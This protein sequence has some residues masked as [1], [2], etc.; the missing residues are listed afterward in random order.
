[1]L[2]FK[3]THTHTPLLGPENDSTVGCVAP[4]HLPSTSLGVIHI[5]ITREIRTRKN[6]AHHVLPVYFSWE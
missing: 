5:G 4:P 6:L 3:H 2:S 1:M